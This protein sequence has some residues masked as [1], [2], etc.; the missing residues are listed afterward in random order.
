MA[1]TRD[2]AA[3]STRPRCAG[4]YGRVPI[5]AQAIRQSGEGRHIP[6]DEVEGW[7][8]WAS[9]QWPPKR[10]S[11]AD[12]NKS[13]NIVDSKRGIVRKSAHGAN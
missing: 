9:S 3:G 11:N 12:V 6:F 5:Y 1:Q 7:K 13:T 8:A 4:R 2:S 10:L